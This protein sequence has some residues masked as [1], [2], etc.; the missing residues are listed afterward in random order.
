MKLIYFWTALK[1]FHNII[2]LEL[3]WQRL[4]RTLLYFII[5]ILRTNGVRVSWDQDVDHCFADWFFF[6]FLI[7]HTSPSCQGH[8]LH[9]LICSSEERNSVL[10]PEW[11]LK[12]LGSTN[13]DGRWAREPFTVR[14][15]SRDRPRGPSAPNEPL[16]FSA[17][18]PLLYRRQWEDDWHC[19]RLCVQ[20]NI[21]CVC[22]TWPCRE[23]WVSV[24]FFKGT[25]NI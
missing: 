7:L 6:F 25:S 1:P 16:H 4:V 13:S 5:F 10:N 24:A 19:V 9:K 17:R 21:L 15:E 18:C 14:P 23:K 3:R 8:L 20:R 22:C 11:E 2:F 12:R